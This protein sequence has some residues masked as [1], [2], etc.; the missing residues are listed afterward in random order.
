MTF[1]KYT[2]IFILFMCLSAC[3]N[4]EQE[5]TSDVAAETAGNNSTAVQ[6]PVT[7]SSESP[8]E[9][10]NKVRNTLRMELPNTL[11]ER[12]GDVE[13][14]KSYSF[15]VEDNYGRAT[16]VI[17]EKLYDP[18]TNKLTAGAE[19][20][21]LW[22]VLDVNSIRIIKTPDGKWASLSIRPTKGNTFIYHPYSNEPDVAVAEVALGWYESVQEQTLMRLYT[23]MKQLADKMDQWE[24]E[25]R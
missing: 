17:K 9:L 23:S 18:V 16:W 6:P 12:R 2:V 8:K 19:Y 5:T 21:L 15:D 3:Q 20:M 7:A 22:E 24:F 11:V 25:K 4:K 14:T 1:M 10:R 13:V